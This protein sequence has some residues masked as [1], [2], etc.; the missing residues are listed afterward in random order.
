MLSSLTFLS[1]RCLTMPAPPTILGSM[2]RW[3][4]PT[5][6]TLVK[7]PKRWGKKVSGCS[8]SGASLFASATH[9]SLPNAESAMNLATSLICAPSPATQPDAIGVG[10]HTSLAHMIF[11]ARLTPTKWGGN[12]I[13]PSLAS[14]ANK[15]VIRAGIASAPKE[16]LSQHHPSHLLSGPAPPRKQL[17]P[18]TQSPLKQHPTTTI[19][20]HHLQRTKVKVG[21][22]LNRL[23]PPNAKLP[24]WMTS[25]SAS[26][27]QEFNLTGKG[28]RNGQRIRE[29]VLQVWLTLRP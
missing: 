5:W 2:P 22:R 19:R 27:P 8:E 10:G 20:H 26:S 3:Y 29:V 28:P 25:Q 11:C 12:A 15:Q 24:P 4:L 9:Q 13:A 18:Q 16:E 23:S 14:S 17:R 6:I 21:Q 1:P 7:S